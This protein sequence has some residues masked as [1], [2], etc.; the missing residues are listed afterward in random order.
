MIIKLKTNKKKIG[1]GT[2]LKLE[3]EVTEIAGDK[4]DYVTLTIKVT[5][6][7]KV[8]SNDF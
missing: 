3:G 8:Y 6:F 1:I 5:V 7:E 4:T 2:R